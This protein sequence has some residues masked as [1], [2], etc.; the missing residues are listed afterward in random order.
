MR[1]RRSRSA[2]ITIVGNKAFSSRRIIRTM[3]HDRPYG[4]PLGITYIPV[5]SQ[6]L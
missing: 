5:M 2:T 1:A 4:I 3:R 6:D